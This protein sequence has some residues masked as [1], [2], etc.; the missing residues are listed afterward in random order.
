MIKAEC[1]SDDYEVEVSF[2]ATPW[3]ERAS[4]GELFDLARCEYG[5]DYPADCIAL[6]VA[7]EQSDE[8]VKEMFA[9]LNRAHHRRE[10]VGYECHVDP[11]DAEVWLAEHRPIVLSKIRQRA[12]REEAIE[13]AVT[14]RE[15]EASA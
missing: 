1:H 3:F 9:Y 4:T 15:S 8:G 13:D 6:Y 10:P 12:E 7:E 11:E 5:G 14:K 2:D